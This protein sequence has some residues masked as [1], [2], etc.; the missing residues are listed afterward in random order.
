ML[1]RS[2]VILVLASLLAVGSGLALSLHRHDGSHTGGDHGRSC[3]LCARLVDRSE[4][5]PP[6]GPVLMPLFSSAERAVGQPAIAAH[7]CLHRGPAAPRAPP[8]C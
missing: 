1:R 3:D 2:C 6:V 7:T 4:A 8:V 5:L